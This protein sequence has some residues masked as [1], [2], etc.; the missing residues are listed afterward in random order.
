MGRDIRGSEFDGSVFVNPNKL[1]WRKISRDDLS[2]VEIDYDPNDVV[3][4][5][6]F[7]DKKHVYAKHEDGRYTAYYYIGQGV[8]DLRNFVWSNGKWTFESQG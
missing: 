5:I 8:R 4:H 1:T 3:T 6:A 2:L 7:D